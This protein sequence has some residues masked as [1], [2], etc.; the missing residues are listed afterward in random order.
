[1]RKQK[2]IRA[3]KK[4]LARSFNK[5]SSKGNSKPRPPPMGQEAAADVSRAIAAWGRAAHAVR[6]SGFPDKL[7]AVDVAVFLPLC[8][9]GAA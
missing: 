9:Q 1:M 5:N 8:C 4:P 7:R 6:L 2:D 3:R